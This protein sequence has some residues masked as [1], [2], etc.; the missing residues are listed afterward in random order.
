MNLKIE[1]RFR[2]I[3]A[4]VRSHFNLYMIAFFLNRNVLILEII[5]IIVDNSFYKDV[6]FA[7]IAKEIKFRNAIFLTCN[8]IN[9]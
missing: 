2:G 6:A 1:Y 8:L 3:N 5:F 7:I 9:F 4:D